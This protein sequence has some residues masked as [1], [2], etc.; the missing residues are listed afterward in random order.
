MALASA[1][2]EAFLPQMGQAPHAWLASSTT[3]RYM[4]L[5]W[6]GRAGVLL[7]LTSFGG[8]RSS[9]KPIAS[10]GPSRRD[11]GAV[12]LMKAMMRS[13]ENRTKSAYPLG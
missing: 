12:T 3:R 6:H 13:I 4:T 10:C 8:N 1:S 5:L 11:A 9:G 2:I 7:A